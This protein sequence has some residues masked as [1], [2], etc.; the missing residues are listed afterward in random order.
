[1]N[2]FA[3]PSSVQAGKT[4][5]GTY[6]LVVL[7]PPALLMLVHCATLF[8][9]STSFELLVA[10]ELVYDLTLTMP[11]LA[12]GLA[13][14]AARSFAR[15]ATII[16]RAVTL[17]ALRPLLFS[18]CSVAAILLLA[19]RDVN[20]WILSSQSGWYGWQSLL[21]YAAFLALGAVRVVLVNFMIF[22][23]SYR[24][25]EGWGCLYP[26]KEGSYRSGAA[27]P[28]VTATGEHSAKLVALHGRHLT[29]AVAPAARNERWMASRS[30][31][32]SI[33]LLLADRAAS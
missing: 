7:A 13:R 26:P 5:S 8:H 28:L 4:Y 14:R 1:V 3:E 11:L 33:K 30:E 2:R 12:P 29:L 24:D 22:K 21:L 16:S 10:I 23:R 18:V 17:D 32:A 6:R 15:D 25:G 19:Q 9:P 27:S 31:A 20:G